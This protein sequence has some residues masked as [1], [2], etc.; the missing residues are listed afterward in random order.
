MSF[1]L[2]IFDENQI[3][4][5]SLS[6]QTALL[7]QVVSV[8]FSGSGSRSFAHLGSRIL[9]LSATPTFYKWR[10]AGATISTSGATVYVNYT[11]GKYFT[12]NLIIGV[13]I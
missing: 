12:V 6:S 11:S 8:Q 5:L 2:E 1:G 7:A 4:I 13:L 3:K 10:L 9:I